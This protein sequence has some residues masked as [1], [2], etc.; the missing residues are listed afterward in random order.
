MATR[1]IARKAHISGLSRAFSSVRSTAAS[2]SIIY[3]D[4]RAV[5]EYLQFHYATPEELMPYKNGPHNAMD[6]NNRLAEVCKGAVQN[7][8]RALDVGCAVGGASFALAKHFDSVCGVDFSHAF[9]K[10]ANQ[11]KGDGKVPYSVLDAA[12]EIMKD[13]VATPPE[14][15]DPARLQFEQGDA[16]DLR[17]DIG[18]FDAVL[19][20]NLLCRLPRP[21]DLLRRLPEL[22]KP[23]GAAVLV[24]PY[25]WLEEY[26]AREEWLGGYVKAD[27]SAAD[28]FE[29][30]SELLSGHFELV[31]REDMPF[32]I[33]EHA[34]KYQWAISDASVWKR[35]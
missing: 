35:V 8:G 23:G 24:S 14:G 12:P 26:T 11:M 25:S 31:S 3:E 13:C 17:A 1:L 19:C 34:R 5:H 28:S 30:V 16:C 27:G 7:T 21:K 33:R 29:A 22:V 15:V 18:E 2:G 6:W 20:S 4:E 9:V 10:A 32:M